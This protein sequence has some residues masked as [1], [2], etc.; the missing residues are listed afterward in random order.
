MKQEEARQRALE[1]GGIAVSAHQKFDSGGAP[2]GWS[3]GGWPGQKGETRIVV[4]PLPQRR[5]DAPQ[6]VLDDT[7]TPGDEIG[8]GRS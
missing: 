4:S 2:A 7:R 1:L 6:M 8:D 3:L 5:K